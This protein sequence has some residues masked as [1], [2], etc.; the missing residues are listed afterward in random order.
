MQRFFW[1]TGDLIL[2]Q[3]TLIAQT[4]EN[5]MQSP[6]LA[7]FVK[8]NTD[9]ATLSNLPNIIDVQTTFS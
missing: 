6:S 5:K 3:H 8:A 1:G 7:V 9:T 2:V 4:N